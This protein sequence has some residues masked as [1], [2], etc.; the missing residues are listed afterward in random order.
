MPE[1]QDILN[2][3]R[4]ARL[5]G[6]PKKLEQLQN[7]PETQRLFQLLQQN[8]GDDLEQAAQQAAQ[9]DAGQLMAAV[10]QLTRSP[11]GKRLIQRLQ[12]SLD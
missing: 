8:A 12:Q 6:D 11:E 7:A 1:F 4:A 2:S 10:R 3:Q 5:M 9:G